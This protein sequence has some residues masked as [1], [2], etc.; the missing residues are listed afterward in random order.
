MTKPKLYTERQQHCRL[1]YSTEPSL[2][3][4]IHWSQSNQ[5]Q[6]YILLLNALLTLHKYG[7][8]ALDIHCL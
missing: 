4:T 7:H 2:F 3:R 1:L 5:K 6:Y 8:G